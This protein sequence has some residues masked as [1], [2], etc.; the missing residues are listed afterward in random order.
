[1]NAPRAIDH[2]GLAE[3]ILVIDIVAAFLSENVGH[4]VCVVFSGGVEQALVY[5]Y[6]FVK[7]KLRWKERKRLTLRGSGTHLDSNVMA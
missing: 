4:E 2:D 7:S 3:P 5:P 1:M 6:S